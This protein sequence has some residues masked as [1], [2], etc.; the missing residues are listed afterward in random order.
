M[1]LTL[2]SGVG[3]QCAHFALWTC[4][5]ANGR[6]LS[7]VILQQALTSFCW[8]FVSEKRVK[9]LLAEASKL[10]PFINV[11]KYKDLGTPKILAHWKTY[12]S[13]LT[14]VVDKLYDLPVDSNDLMRLRFLYRQA[15]LELIRTKQ[16]KR[17]QTDQLER[18]FD[19]F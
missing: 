18:P 19:F 2:S 17:S 6:P 16:E 9:P 5:I 3:R 8:P 15:Y 12:S 11:Y 7:P 13:Q 14:V 10:S 1:S 4:F